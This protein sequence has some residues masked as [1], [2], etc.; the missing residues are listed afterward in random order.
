MALNP[1]QD[2]R[3]DGSGSARLTQDDRIA[4]LTTPLGKDVLVLVRF[5]GTEGLSELF[6]YRIEALSDKPDL[7]FDKAIGQQCQL[8]IKTYGAGSAG[9]GPEIAAPT[10]LPSPSTSARPESLAASSGGSAAQEREFNGILVEARW[11]GVKQQYY[12][13]RLV[14]RPWLWLLSHTSDCRIFQD[15]KA[16]DIIKEVFQD[17][18]FT[19]FEFKLTDEGSLPKLEY[20]VQY[21]ET[22]LNF[23]SRLM[24]QHGIY[25][26]FKHKDQKHTLVLAD[27]K[28]SHEPVPGCDKIPYIPA[29][30]EWKRD[31]ERIYEWASERRFRT[32]K[33]ELNDYN[34]LTP[35]ARLLSDH[36]ASENYTRS[37]MEHY[38]YPGKYKKK[39]EGDFYAKI[40]LEAEQAPDHRRH[41]N[42][43][44]MSLFPGGLTTLERHPTQSQNV[45]YLIVRS[46][47]SFVVELYRTSGQGPGGENYYGS[48]E[49]LPYDKQ[50]RAPIVT[51]KPL[52]HGIQT[53]KVV[54]KDDNSS[55]EIEVEELTEIYVRFYWDRKKKRSCK[56]RVAQ[57][58]SGKK[59]G[60]Q[61]IPRVGQEAVVEFLEGDPDRPLVVGTV[62]ND[63]YKPPYELP[64]KKTISGIKSDST[65][66]GNGYNEWNF[67]DKKGSE[68]IGVHAE[69]DLEVVVLNSETR[70][71]GER[72]MPPM[73]SPSRNT[74][75]KM[76]DDNL[77]VQTGNQMVDVMMN[78]THKTGVTFTLSAGM[79]VSTIMMDPSGI[80]ITAPTIMITGMA[81]VTISAPSIQLIGADVACIG[82]SHGFK[83]I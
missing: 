10:S 25:Y 44:A 57:V 67:E 81:S 30:G 23:V 40:Q 56:L 43:D 16:S 42:G 7:D 12:S 32:G 17:R 9:Q 74:T 79:G 31:Q 70:T 80:K 52:I 39:S 48:Y 72:F 47:H 29:S 58:W 13:Y 77:K 6:E 49:F 26:F 59:W 22:D 38:D 83:P 4:R 2:D 14:L 68:K 24:E 66:G 28:S 63:D 73:G 11:L 18:G 75:L 21:R 5:D 76:G 27:S 15:K 69:K 78:T 71:I 3:F 36:K 54:T 62:Y 61:H 19:D 64:A 35:N 20:C 8:K 33:V 60:Q 65:K 82:N 55:E 37:D 41:G 53:A 45:K 51:L 50:F 1:M 34:Y 46:T